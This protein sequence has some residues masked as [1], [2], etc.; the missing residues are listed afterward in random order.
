[1]KKNSG[2][3]NVI[4]LYY[5][6]L[7]KTKEE[8]NYHWFP[9]SV[10]PLAQSLEKAGYEPIIIDCR[11]ENRNIYEV[12]DKH[13]ERI[14]FV[15]IS[16]MSGYQITDGLRISKY[17]RKFNPNIPIV[18]GGWHPTILP[19]ETAE[20]KLVDF[21]VAGRGEETVVELADGI[22][23][24]REFTGMKGVVYKNNSKIIFNGYKKPK[25]LTDDAQSYA[26]YINI[27]KYIN[28][29]TKALGY[30][31]GHGCVYKCSFCS[32]H[33][34]TNKEYFYSI[35][36]V[37]DDLKYYVKLYGFKH[38]HFQDDT[39]F[40][41]MKRIIELAKQIINKELKITWWANARANSFHK[42]DKKDIDLLVDSGM[43]SLFVGVESASDDLL[44]LVNK[45]IKSCDILKMADYLKKW[46]ISLFLSYIL[47]LPG[48]NPDR[49]KKNTDQIKQLKKINSNIKIQICFYQPYPGTPLYPIALEWGCPKVKG[50]EKWGVMKSQ[51]EM[52]DM[53]WL[54]KSQIKL[55]KKEYMD[56]VDFLKE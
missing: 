42:A 38:I 19:E 45:G 22:K 12:L 31:S 32:R 40:I 44:K 30:F 7:N 56:L 11:V 27:K 28:P 24:N 39:L 2:S 47:G 51:G 1:M 26:K 41:N 3:K 13:K 36:K 52:P 14:L 6:L 8:R 43:R 55:Y 5:P 17:V 9:Y 54:N 25:N 53:P 35:D 29:E 18:W 50:L 34:M 33:F 49:I 16:A 21:V 23:F 10:L 48:D 37:I 15:G 20:H 4:V 46:D